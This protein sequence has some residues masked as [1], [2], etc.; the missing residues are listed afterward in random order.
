[1]KKIHSCFL[2]SVFFALAIFCGGERAFAGDPAYLGVTIKKVQL[3]NRNGDWVTL[4]EP[5]KT[6]D[7]RGDEPVAEFV[8]KNRVPAGE[9]VNVKITLSETFHISGSDGKNLTK[10]G[11]EI[12]V[13]GSAAKAADL[14]GDLTSVRQSAP[15]WNT[16]SE[17]EITEHLSLDY[18]DRD[19]M[20]E[21]YGKREFKK[22]LA[23]K[24]GSEVR[25]TMG[26]ELR[27][28]LHFVWPNFFSGLTEE[29]M[30]FLPPKDVSEVSVKSGATTVLL[31]SESL[32]WAF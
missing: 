6:I 2:I 29:A 9:Y 5:N 30:Y 8:N 23:I 26:I 3:K 31:T 4:A 11:G 10:Q 18:E 25:V 7:L 13:A 16:L 1:M 21:I 24:E 17:G 32:E 28:T 15:T 20:M 27:D 12:T 14:P 22:P 19:D